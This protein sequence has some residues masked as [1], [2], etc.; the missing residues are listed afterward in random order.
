MRPQRK[1][2]EWSEHEKNDAPRWGNEEA[3]EQCS[4]TGD[5]EGGTRQGQV[6]L[7]GA[8]AL[9]SRPTTERTKAAA[10]YRL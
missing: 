10:I 2:E 1:G 7:A 5:Q 3:G 9:A 4:E 8:E 6:A